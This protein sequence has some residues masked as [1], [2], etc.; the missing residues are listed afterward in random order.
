MPASA[1]P[2]IATLSPHFLWN[3]L[4]RKAWVF[5]AAS[6]PIL[7][8]TVLYLVIAKSA[9]EST[10]TIQI[11][12]KERPTYRASAQEEGDQNQDLKS[13]DE[14][15]TI[16][17]NLQSDDLYLAVAARPEI[18]NDPSLLVGY[19]GDPTH[20]DDKSLA[21][22]IQSDTLVNLRHGTRLID[23]S[24]YHAV[25]AMAQKLAKAV[26]EEFAA[27]N[28]RL[29]GVRE[30]DV[31]SKLQSQIDV[32]QLELQKSETTLSMYRHTLDDKAQIDN[33]KSQI[34]EAEAEYGPN[35]PD[36]EQE[37]RLLA[38]EL[39]DADASFHSVL[40]DSPGE[41]AYWAANSD[42]LNKAAPS[43][44]VELELELVQGR[45]DILQK[46]L[47]SE[48]ELMG[49]ITR[50]MREALINQVAGATQFDL[51][52]N[53]QLPLTP[54]KPKKLQFL[55]LGF[56]IAMVAGTA[57]VWISHILDPSVHTPMDAEMLLGLPIIGTIP[58][59]HPRTNS[60]HTLRERARR[61]FYNGK[62][63]ASGTSNGKS[64][65]EL[66]LISAEGP[67]LPVIL[68]HPD[69]P[70]AEAFRSLRAMIE[71]ADDPAKRRSFLIVSA[72]P[73]EGKT[74][75]ASN[76]AASMG[77]A[78]R[79]TLLVDTDL[80]QPTVH[81]K[82]Q[83]E[84]TIGFLDVISGHITLEAAV[85]PEVSDGLDILTAGSRCPNPAE[86][87]A[88][89]AFKDLLKSALAT[90]DRVIFDSSPINLVSDALLMA[91]HVDGV[92]C[93][94]RATTAAR[95]GIQYGLSLLSRAS[96][97]PGGLI[98][99]ALAPHSEQSYLSY[100][101]SAGSPYRQVYGSVR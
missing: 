36:I 97:R 50:Q 81:V 87:F 53:P 75:V 4:R 2:Q 63:P 65:K 41:A 43:D 60:P 90:Y 96:K 86:L 48:T 54:A 23:V 30:Q 7:V 6:V 85:H 89:A 44:R 33:Q 71:L 22:W 64:S 29:E 78:G 24:V 12:D 49:N 47:D 15:K 35:Y 61:Q 1:L 100:S 40:N 32:A 8:A 72:L 28:D 20:L 77:K 82:F 16:E 11:A 76:L 92:F 51:V 34:Q 66:N 59:I 83:I 74:T 56:V 62:A 99:N 79:K 58:R 98:L 5:L 14:I 38:E 21:V 88:G 25:P 95:S 84:N 10:A 57:A 93:V 37:Q 13:D 45:V 17:Q 3:L 46:Q 42:E 52:G 55:L 94:V 67:P 18:R 27:Q 73:G 69:G 68:S 80:R 70:E 101:S 31:R 9:Y 26:V 19:S 91:P 39:S